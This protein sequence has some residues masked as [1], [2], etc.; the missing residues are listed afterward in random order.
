M[1]RLPGGRGKRTG[2]DQYIGQQE[3]RFAREAILPDEDG[4]IISPAG[5][6]TSAE[7]AVTAVLPTTTTHLHYIPARLAT[8]QIVEARA[9]I[10]FAV[11]NQELQAALYLYSNQ[12]FKMIPGT[13]AA[14]SSTTT[15][16]KQQ[17]L[18]RP[19]VIAPNMRVFL[20]VRATA[21]TIAVQGFKSGA[22]A[23]PRVLRSRKDGAGAT[24]LASTYDT[25]RMA[26]DNTNT[27]TALVVFL[28]REASSVL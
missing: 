24:I 20:G 22:G 16:L 28:A 4:W 23:T 26:L 1:R 15:G 9:N 12:E 3:S 10:A 13:Y 8:A 5:D 7:T 21:A 11:A 2:E 17:S 25:A 6:T 27:D 18:S 14:F 19:I